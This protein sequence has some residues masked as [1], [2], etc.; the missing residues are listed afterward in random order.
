MSLCQFARVAP[1]PNAKQIGFLDF[2]AHFR[3][4]IVMRSLAPGSVLAVALSIVPL[5]SAR[6]DDK[7]KW[8]MMTDKNQVSLIYGDASEESDLVL[9]CKPH[10]NSVRF[11]IGETDASLKPKMQVTASFTVGAAK[12][13]ISGKTVPNELAGVPG[14]IGELAA[15]D[16]LFDAMAGAPAISIKVAKTAKEISLKTMGSKAGAFSKA[17]RKS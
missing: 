9:S 6:A 3:T 11:F 5:I 4:S 12:A 2:I 17:C 14:F 7:P 10:S 15:T 1:G 16:P 13:A 8:T